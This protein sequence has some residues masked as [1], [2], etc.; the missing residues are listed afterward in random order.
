[1]AATLILAKPSIRERAK[2]W[3]DIAPD[4]TVVTFVHDKRT[5]LQNARLH[6][7]ITDIA[8]QKLYNGLKLDVKSWKLVFMDALNMEVLIVPNLAN[9]G[10]VNLGSSTSRLNKALCSDLM[11][12]IAA[13]GA[14][15]GVV[16]SDP[17][18]ADEP[19]NSPPVERVTA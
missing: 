8:K 9:T 6:A 14:Q 3:I 19:R 16:F 15:N 2:H 10:F 12:I 18:Y 17:K 13:W 5:N 11:E 1:M 4:E 7:M